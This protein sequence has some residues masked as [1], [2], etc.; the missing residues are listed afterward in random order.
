M[1]KNYFLI[2][3]K[4][5]IEKAI[6][7]EIVAI[8]FKNG[9]VQVDILPVVGRDAFWDAVVELITNEQDKEESKE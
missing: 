7:A 2:T 3:L 4:A 9:L 1:I 8:T 5:T 6:N